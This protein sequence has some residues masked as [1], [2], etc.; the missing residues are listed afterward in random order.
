MMFIGRASYYQQHAEQRCCIHAY[1]GFYGVWH[2]TVPGNQ[3]GLI[4]FT[5]VICSPLFC[6][7]TN[8]RSI[9][10]VEDT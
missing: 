10:D 5:K 1:T 7:S 2:T 9:S 8:M 3:I 6:N 4:L